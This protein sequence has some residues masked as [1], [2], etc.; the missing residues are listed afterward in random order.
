M[1][2]CPWTSVSGDLPA[3]LAQGGE[4]VGGQLGGFPTGENGGQLLV[5]VRWRR[6][7]EHGDVVDAVELEAVRREVVR[8]SFE[9]GMLGGTVGAASGSFIGEAG[10]AVIGDRFVLRSSWLLEWSTRTAFG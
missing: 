2:L 7:T 5:Q 8:W 3:P 4:D 9:D 10:G 1:A 6:L